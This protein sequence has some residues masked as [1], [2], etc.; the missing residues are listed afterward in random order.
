MEHLGVVFIVTLFILMVWWSIKGTLA[1]QRT[2]KKRVEELER[3]ITHYKRLLKEAMRVKRVDNKR[4][5][6][7]E[8]VELFLTTLEQAGYTLTPQGE[9]ERRWKK[10]NREHRQAFTVHAITRYSHHDLME[11]IKKAEEDAKEY[12]NEVG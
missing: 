5:V 4:R 6:T 11:I 8:D 12:L 1:E 9:M 3:D 2:H 10:G 7:V